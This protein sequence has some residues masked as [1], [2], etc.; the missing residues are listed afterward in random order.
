MHTS[1][2]NTLSYLPQAAWISALRILFFLH[3]VL[4]HLSLPVTLRLQTACY[5][6]N[7]HLSHK[8]CFPL[9]LPHSICLSPFPC[10]PQWLS[11]AS[12]PPSPPPFHSQSRSLNQPMFFY[13]FLSLSFRDTLTHLYFT[14]PPHPPTLQS[15]LLN[16]IF[17][18][19]MSH[20]VALG[21]LN[22]CIQ[23]SLQSCI[24][25]R[26]QGNTFPHGSQYKAIYLTK[27]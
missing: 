2:T 25:L 9:S 26:W 20:E 16:C 3:F 5:K 12:R 1:C 14:P 10:D 22:G 23:T 8:L 4:F 7:L 15:S 21:V 6:I 13:G 11:P 19:C 18:K 24:P 27:M 17:V